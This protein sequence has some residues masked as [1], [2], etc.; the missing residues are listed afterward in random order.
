MSLSESVAKSRLEILQI[1]R[2]LQSVREAD[3]PY[4]EKLIS[5]GVD[6]LINLTEP[7]EGN[8]VLHLAS[9][10]NNQDLLEFLMAHGASPNVQDRRG[11]T[12]LMLAAELG[13]DGIVS[14]LAKKNANMTLVDNEGKG[15]LFYCIHPTKRHMRCLQVALMGNADA[16]NV[17]ETGMPVFLLACEQAQDCEEMCLSILESGADPNASNQVTGRTA[18]MEATRGGA[19]ELV[20]AIL[21]KG[22]NVNAVDKKQFHAAHFAAERGLFEIIKVLSA[23]AADFGMMT[24]EGDTPLHYAA[25][26]GYTDC[27]KFLVQRGCNP[28]L[29][30]QEGLLP[31]QIAKDCGHKATVKELK[32][33]ERLHGKFSKG[34]GGT[35]EPWAL[36]LHDWSHEYEI[37]LRNAFETA[38]DN[39]AGIEAVSRE[40]FVSVLRD[41]HAPVDDDQ[42]RDLLYA[43]DRRKEG[44][45]DVNDFLRGLKFLP[46][47]YIMA[48]YGSK[49]KKVSKA[50]RTKKSKFNLPVPICT[51][52]PDL[53]QRRDDGGPPHFMIESFQHATDIH[54][55][56]RDHR[57]E[58]PIEDDTAWYIDEPEKIYINMN[59]CV[60]MGDIESLKL[61]VSQK[62][63]VDV[64]DR[65]YKTPLMAAC[66]SGNYEMAKFL[67]DNGA[68]VNACDQFSWT[69]LH[70]ASHAGQLDIIQ[71]LLEAGA[72]VDPPTL[73]GATP[74]MRA[75]E[76]CRPS[77]VDYLIKAG[78]KINAV[79]KT[80]QNCLDV[81]R[82]YADFRVVDLIQAKIHAL[83]RHRDRKA[84]PA[85]VKRKPTPASASGSTKEKQGSVPTLPTSS[86]SA[87]KKAMKKD[88]VVVHS[89]Q[90]SS[91]KLN[92]LDISFV[93]RTTWRNQLTTVE[94]ME[95]KAAR[96]KRFTYEVDFDDFK[97]PFNKNIQKKS[98]DFELTD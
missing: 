23:Y 75:I 65:F 5:M 58:H 59:Y 57:P 41:L 94:M 8:G 88:S 49:K 3:K 81:A 42:I 83:P 31:R 93:P 87:V 60:K 69:P 85:K 64:K 18:L 11:R 82:A 39:Y 47:T 79:N 56:D 24:S 84:Q 30:N 4:I 91:G 76:S 78:A 70:H 68:D 52:P 61:A 38:S 63:P 13:Y 66:A 54:R 72:A 7:R 95:K 36:T 97:M 48:S 6:G 55:Y 14:L 67:V 62:V 50:G 45:V 51:V 35:N 43:L 44:F 2:L 25:A 46:K 53:I 74:L 27:C 90:I 29:K 40:T 33:V 22:G 86:N 34:M 71:L 16:N 15:L 19:V 80:E 37:A 26:G 9:V 21:R 89:T 77:C 98:V 10:A 1:Y 17:S 28:K 32:K 12:P 92:K 73:N 20:R 96:R